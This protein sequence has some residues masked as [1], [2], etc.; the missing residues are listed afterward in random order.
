MRTLHHDAARRARHR[1]QAAVGAAGLA[2]MLGG[3]TFAV[4]EVAGARS[5]RIALPPAV[6]PAA[7][8]RSPSATPSPARTSHA[9]YPPGRSAAAAGTSPTPARSEAA[10]HADSGPGS[11]ARAR[12]KVKRAPLPQ[13]TTS[14]LTAAVTQTQSG[15]LRTDGRMMRVVSAR[16]DLTGLRELAWVADRGVPVGDARC[17]QRF[18][19]V[20]GAPA[21]EKPT[22]LICWRTS[23]AKSVYT[24]AVAAEGRPSTAASVAAI[25]ARWTAMG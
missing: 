22:L 15:T 1:K 24:V 16:Q 25:D 3:G 21:T 14:V 11:A 10:A 13:T 23:A 4:T 20:A 5:G 9:P 18:R 7:A 17:S 19:F 2:A 12:D 6:P 8:T